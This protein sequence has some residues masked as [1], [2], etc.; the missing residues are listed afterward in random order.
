MTPLPRISIDDVA[1]EEW[2]ESYQKYLG[3]LG[4]NVT[5]PA[6]DQKASNPKDAVGSSKLPLDLVP[7][8]LT[9]YAAASF[10]EGA[11]KYGAYNWRV[12]GARASIYKAALERHL[13][14]WWNG[15]DVDPVTKIPHL[16][17]VIACAGIILDAEACGKLNDDRPPRVSMTEVIQRLEEA[18]AH[19]RKLNA[20]CN[21][22][23][24]TQKALEAA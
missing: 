4:Q 14:K 9:F 15:E 13:S 22:V 3:G 18:V 16:A 2:N 24:N 23:H 10:A 17:S 7:S 6:K 21:P 1:P 11:S 12:A 5:D 8:T 20:D 19:V